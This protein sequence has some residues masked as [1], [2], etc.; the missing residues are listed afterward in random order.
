MQ[1]SSDPAYGRRSGWQDQR[2]NNG[3]SRRRGDVDQM[4]V[5]QSRFRSLGC[6]L[7]QARLIIGTQ[8]EMP[9]SKRAIHDPMRFQISL[10][11]VS[12]DRRIRGRKGIEVAF[13]S[14]RIQ[15]VCDTD[16]DFWHR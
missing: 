8:G 9:P 7:S 1:S 13:Y 6:W 4:D 10:V 5:R 3:Q 11:F 14:S 2:S 16:I 15:V 12:S